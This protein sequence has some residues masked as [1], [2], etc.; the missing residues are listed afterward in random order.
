MRVSSVKYLLKDCSA[1]IRANVSTLAARLKLRSLLTSFLMVVTAATATAAL[2][3]TTPE[4]KIANRI[5]PVGTVCLE[6]QPCASAA[7]AVAAGGGGDQ[8]KTGEEIYTGFCSTCHS[9]GVAGA[10]KVGNAGDWAPRIEKGVETLISNAINGIGAMP[11]MG[12]CA[13]CDEEDIG[14]AVKHMVEASQ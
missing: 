1:M 5:A 8:P 7:P 9:V 4:E 2:A 6:G 13:T 14:N 11:P 12:T 10:P 3:Y